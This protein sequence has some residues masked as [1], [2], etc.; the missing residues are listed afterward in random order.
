VPTLAA[1]RVPRP[2]ASVPPV[3]LGAVAA[4]D[5]SESVA[6]VRDGDATIL[7]LDPLEVVRA[8]GATALAALDSLTPGWWAGFLAYDLGRA[9]E[10][11]RARRPDAHP[12]PAGLPDVAL[13]RFAA[14]AE[15]VPEGVALH[16]DAPGRARLASL[17]SDPA[18]PTRAAVG[19][20]APVSS[21]DQREYE[22]GVR[23]I[24]ELL[25]AGECYQ[26]NLTR[27]LQWQER[28][29]T[30]ALFGALARDNP[31]PHTALV[32][33][34]AEKD[35]A[36]EVV[37]ASPERFLHWDGPTVETRPIKGTAASGSD[38]VNSPKDHAENVMI[39]DLAR[40]DLGRV[41]EYGSVHVPELCGLE[42]H[43][44]LHHLVSTVRGQLRPGVGVGGLVAATFPPASVTGAP[45]PRVLQAI[46]ELEPVRRGVYC[47]AVG[48]LDT[49]RAR[50][51][52]AVA[53]RT[54]VVDGATTSLGVGA[55]IVAD[56]DPVCEWRETELKAARLL[57]AAGV[58]H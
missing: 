27:R 21:L 30:T 57:R 42:E 20:S 40:N 31:A 26:V 43:P 48:W 54:F 2:L 6:V 13:V 44:G 17:L 18:P 25:R 38:L 47:G 19:L 52:L 11:V 28:A 3:V 14:R 8:D 49:E 45:K 51:D 50:G 34:P 5:P 53:I 16:G 36:L 9:I 22:D 56:S 4:L 10:P 12:A 1:A 15:L 37:S 58:A 41:C 29:D 23:A 35:V 39:V 24:V 32:R 33:L 46:E 55:G 7:A